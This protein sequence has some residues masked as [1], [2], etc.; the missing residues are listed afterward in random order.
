MQTSPTCCTNSYKEKTS[1]L[2]SCWS[3]WYAVYTRANHEKRV[4][5]Q[6]G[7]RSVQHFIPLYDSVRRWKDRQV[8]LRMPLFPGYLFVRVTPR[9]Q[10]RVLQVPGVARLVGFSGSPTPLADEEIEGLRDAL[11]EGVRAEP[12]P[13]LRVGRRV[14]ITTGPLSGR[15]GILKRWKGDLRVVLSTDLIQ[16][17]VLVDVDASSVVPVHECSPRM[18]I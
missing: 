16:R 2:E 1:S 8:K 4:A 11:A 7:E 18:A 13:Y 14:R 15:E 12:H 17:S 6:F 10:I 3:Q 9:E 5:E